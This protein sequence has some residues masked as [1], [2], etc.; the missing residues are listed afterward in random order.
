MGQSF[1]RG[2]LFVCLKEGLTQPSSAARHTTEFDEVLQQHYGTNIPAVI[3]LDTDGG[4]DHNPTLMSVKL[5]LIATF[6]RSNAFSFDG[7]YFNSL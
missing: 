7:F 6:T 1:Y 5:G 3:L 2:H 4:P